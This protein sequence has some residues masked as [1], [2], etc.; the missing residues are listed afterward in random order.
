LSLIAV[1]A[2][3]TANAA[4]AFSAYAIAAVTAAA[5][6][7]AITILLIQFNIALTEPKM[8]PTKEG[9]PLIWIHYKARLGMQP[10]WL[11]LKHSHTLALTFGI[12]WQGGSHGCSSY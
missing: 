4:V 3:A 2:P 10:G 9:S 1:I 6:T 7:A 5:A 11:Q 12:D 8:M